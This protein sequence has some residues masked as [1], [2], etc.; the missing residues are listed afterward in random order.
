MSAPKK[1]RESIKLNTTEFKHMNEVNEE[2]AMDHE[3]GIISVCRY[4]YYTDGNA[5]ILYL[6]KAAYGYCTLLLFIEIIY[7]YIKVAQGR[8]NT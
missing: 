8:K 2:M 4:I 1:R 7:I 6:I 5:K 3:T